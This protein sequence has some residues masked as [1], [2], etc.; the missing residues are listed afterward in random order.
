MKGFFVGILW[1]AS[2]LGT[3]YLTSEFLDK[4][5]HQRYEMR[6]KTDKEKRS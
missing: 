5:Y 4:E 3:A 6:L 1:C 2:V